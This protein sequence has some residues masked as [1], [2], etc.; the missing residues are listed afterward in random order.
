MTV[1][2]AKGERLSAEITQTGTKSQE[3]SNKIT[4]GEWLISIE[5]FKVDKTTKKPEIERVPSLLRQS[6]S[7]ENCYDPI[8][9]SIGPYHHGKPGLETFEQL[10]IPIAQKL[11]RNHCNQVSI[12]QLYE[13][14]AKVGKSARECYA[15]VST[16]DCDDEL[17]NRMMFLDACFVLHFMFILNVGNVSNGTYKEQKVD[18]RLYM[19]YYQG[20]IGSDLFLLENQ[21]PLLVLRVLMNFM[22][23]SDQIQ[24]EFIQKFLESQSIS[25][26]WD[27]SKELD[28]DGSHIISKSWDDSKELDLD[29][30]HT[31]S[32][33][34]D[35]S[36]E[37]DLDGSHTIS[38]SWDASMELD[39]DG[40]HHLLHLI[41][42]RLAVRP[43]TDGSHHL[44][45]LIWKRLAVRPNTD[46]STATEEWE[47]FR[48][49]TELKSAGIHVKPSRTGILTH[50]EFKS[51]LTFG[52]LTLP[53]MF[54]DDSTKPLL[55]NLVAY[56]LCPY[57]PPGLGITSY[58]CLM[59]S[60][61]D[62]AD[63][64]QELRKR[65]I[66]GN[67]LGSDQELAQ[68]FN[69]IAKDL[70]ADET[71]YAEAKRM[72]EIH[73]H[74]KVQG[75]MA[76]WMHKY[77]SSPWTLSAFLGAILILALTMAQT[78][79]AAYTHYTSERKTS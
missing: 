16:D 1:V 65:K 9:V 60:L 78:Y 29:G 7:D 59:D 36:K 17:F 50:A 54:I 23:D 4:K 33:S 14:V 34:W 69:K 31:I 56:E 26:S 27:D 55:L 62:H 72:I 21:I 22:F 70:V 66:L 37:L 11:C 57:G 63:D 15:K 67:Y 18:P 49:V 40:S 44:L 28:L 3:S 32:K 58:I 5:N 43:N 6:N 2:G 76:E 35:D 73:C 10:K 8:V 41:W 77:F 71:I 42:K 20:L 64:V 61:I 19:G 46:A 38:K 52:T 45:H 30:S 48:T 12:E 24:K 51:R 53:R 79:F 74:S 25:K 75:W 39:L 13:E 47:S 68:F